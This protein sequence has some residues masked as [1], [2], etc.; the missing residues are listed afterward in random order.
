MAPILHSSGCPEGQFPADSCHPG[1][2]PQTVLFNN[3]GE[4]CVK[5]QAAVSPFPG[6]RHVNISDYV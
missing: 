1:L 3:L 6:H 5:S 2:W 4:L